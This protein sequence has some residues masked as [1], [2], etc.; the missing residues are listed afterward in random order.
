MGGSRKDEKGKGK[1][2]ERRSNST[3]QYGARST[4]QDS[5]VH[6]DLLST[7]TDPDSPRVGYFSRSF[8]A[9]APLPL[10]STSPLVPF[11]APIPLPLPP[12]TLSNGLPNP[13]IR[14]RELP[15]TTIR[16]DLSLYKTLMKAR[17]SA[18]VVLTA[19]AGYAMCPLDPTSTTSAMEAFAS[20]LASTL[21]PG[22][23][24]ESLAPGYP[25]PSTNSLTLSGLLPAT[26]GTTLCAASAAAFNQL[27]EAP[28]DAQMTRTRA[29]PVP[30]RFI[31]PLHAS[32]F[33]L[34]SGLTGVGTLYAI[35]PLAASI[36]LGTILLYCPLYTIAKRHTIYN[37]WLGAVVGALP[38]MIGWAACTGSLDPTT[39]PGAYAL[40]LLCF[41][42][43]FPHFNSLA[44]TLRSSYAASGYR[45]LAVLDPPHNALVSLRYSVALIP[46]S[47]LFPPLGLTTSIFPFLA[48]IPNGAMAYAA[49]KFYK[50]REERKAK[51]LFWASL[52]HLPVVLGLAM[53][54]KK[55]LWED[56]GVV[57]EVEEES[58]GSDSDEESEG[59]VERV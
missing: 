44:H 20:T 54:C 7:Q 15:V 46:L 34:V 38:P 16:E 10:P 42:W 23:T 56:E 8:L 14:W 31:T 5:A 2:M 4:L 28:Y 51:L 19:M 40:F 48:T 18:L 49:W 1:A 59:E 24:I 30:R 17:L 13:L 55:D 33:G 52:G 39:Q 36:G 29:R 3:E 9:A 26:V 21:P 11:S 35:N 47:F 32:T 41:F 27:I 12:T 6:E 45:M 58:E 50:D 53:A 25:S 22:T 57:N 37:T 43:Q